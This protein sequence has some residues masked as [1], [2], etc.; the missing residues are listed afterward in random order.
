MKMQRWKRVTARCLL[1]LC[2]AA[3]AL[4]A[5]AARA[6]EVNLAL[7]KPVTASTEY[8]SQPAGK[9]TD[10]NKDSDKGRWGTEA[11]A[12][13]WAYVDLGSKQ[14]IAYVELT[15]ENEGNRAERFEI[16]VSDDAK[17]WGDPVKVVEGNATA[18]SAVELD[19]EVEGRYVKLVVTKVVGYPCVS[20]SEMEVYAKKP[21]GQ[22][23]DK[24]STDAVN[25]AL[26]MK[27]K[28]SRDHHNLNG[29]RAVDGKKKDVAQDRW[30]T[31][32]KPTKDDPQWLVVDLGSA[33]SVKHI[34]AMWENAENYS[35][36]FKVYVSND[37]ACWDKPKENGAWGKPVYETADNKS[38]T[39][40][41]D[42][43]T[44]AN[45]RY[46]KLEITEVVGWGASCMEFEVWNGE[47]PAPE[48]QPADFLSEI[49]VNPVT[50]ETKTLSYDLPA[51][52]EG[53]EIKYN[54]TDYEQ[55]IDADGTIYRPICD[56][57]VKAS[58]KISSKTDPSDYAFKEFDVKVPGSMTAAGA[59]AAPVVLPEL[60]EWVGGSGSFAASTAK[61]VVYGGASLKAM[62]EDFANDYQALT[63][64]RLQ[65]ATGTSAQA[66]D[67]F[68]TLG[69][70][71]AKGLKDE[72]YLLDVTAD[73]MTVTAEAVAGANWGGKTIL[74]GMKSGSGSFPLGTAR[75]YPLYKVRGIILDVGRKT[76]TLDWLKQMTKQMSFYKMNDFQI[77]LNDNLIPLE[78]YKNEDVFQAYSAFRLES[79]VKKGGN[80]G[81][82]KA[83]LT[84]KD[85]WYSKKDF[86]AYIEESKALGVNIIPE[87]DTPAHSLALTKVR[88]DLRHGTSGR[89]N[90]HLDIAKQYDEC[91]KFVR[92]IFDE[93]VKG[94]D[95][96]VFAG[97][98]TIHVGADEYTADGNAY[99]TFVNDMFKYSEDNGKKARV[100]VR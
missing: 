77:H 21:E 3:I 66:G 27:T 63:G 2:A 68:F 34:E 23:P 39:S 97:A 52:P 12:P 53:Y 74:Q 76:F 90:D 91:F 99:R 73:R 88:P 93:Y 98:D 47:P 6:D 36:A 35:K 38:A 33:K 70:D 50:P 58:F 7:K 8:S 18:V 31:E 71:K 43:E 62:A 57:T 80:N 78:H 11:A 64:V 32:T 5:Q 49:V 51:V 4:P 46:V 82:N 89:Q 65:V 100:W 48:K 44:A 79:D 86:K 61:R 87:I 25:M 42:L 96:A 56:V 24:P 95:A 28:A 75:D 45:G 72:G 55:V 1:L 69:A 41:I 37:Q 92:G 83:D 67:I 59:N 81:K 40:R 84:A 22:S 17:T 15:W 94:G 29:A 30:M 16:Y 9:L 13:Q 85:V 14:K 26:G 10:G 19:R 60:R 54:G 20:C